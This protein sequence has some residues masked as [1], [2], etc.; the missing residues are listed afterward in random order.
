MRNLAVLL[1]ALHVVLLDWLH[2]RMIHR[3]VAKS[4]VC[5]AGTS[6]SHGLGW[7]ALLVTYGMP[8]AELDWP[9]ILYILLEEFLLLAAALNVLLITR[10]LILVA[11]DDVKNVLLLVLGVTESASPLILKFLLEP[12]NAVA[13]NITLPTFGLQSVDRAKEES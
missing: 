5:V 12:V 9:L 10:E 11:S 13:D 4:R 2:H 1:A 3:M 6:C 7:H 8:G